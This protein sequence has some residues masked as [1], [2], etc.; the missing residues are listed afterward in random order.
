MLGKEAVN[1][2]SFHILKQNI[3]AYGEGAAIFFLKK[4]INFK[5]MWARLLRVILTK[6]GLSREHLLDLESINAPC[7]PNK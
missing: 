6:H 2:K 5:M 7:M 1:N 4:G 3:C